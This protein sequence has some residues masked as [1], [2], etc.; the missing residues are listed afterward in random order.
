[1]ATESRAEAL[2]A[3]S[4]R[5]TSAE[6]PYLET[7]GSADRTAF[8]MAGPWPHRVRWFVAADPA[9]ANR[10]QARSKDDQNDFDQLD[11]ATWLTLFRPFLD[12][13][14]AAIPNGDEIYV[15]GASLGGAAANMLAEIAATEY[16]ELTAAKYFGFAPLFVSEKEGIFNFGFEERSLLQ[17]TKR[18]CRLQLQHG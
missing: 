10:R 16:P 11:P 9:S 14:V 15:T 5:W 8:T 7:A 18:L 17:V 2:T 12:A 1:M 6:Q 4:S 13:V 3:T